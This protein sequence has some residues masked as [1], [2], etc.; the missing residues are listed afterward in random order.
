M[1]MLNGLPSANGLRWEERNGKEVITFSPQ[2]FSDEVIETSDFRF[3]II[4]GGLLLRVFEEGTKNGRRI[5]KDYLVSYFRRDQ[6]PIWRNENNSFTYRRILDVFDR[7]LV[8][9]YGDAI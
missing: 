3:E 2:L 9:A 6:S 5:Y 4:S 1:N 8:A 7:C